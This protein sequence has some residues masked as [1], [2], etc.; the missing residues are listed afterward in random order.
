ML[1]NFLII[2]A[3]R[4][5]TSYISK[6]IMQHPD[7]FLHPQKELHFFD[8]HYNKG[9]DYY[10]TFFKNVKKKAVGE[11][12]PAYLYFAHIPSLIK[13]HIPNIKLI[14]SLRNPTDRAY[15]H[16]WN[17]VAR[18]KM[19]NVKFYDT[20][21]NHLDS[22]GRLIKEG[23]YY[24]MLVRYYNVFPK[25]KILILFYEELI[26]KTDDNFKK[27]FSFLGVDYSF[28]PSIRKF[29]LNSSSTK[30]ANSIAIYYIYLFLIKK[31][32]FYKAANIIDKFNK[33]EIPEMNLKTRKRLDLIFDDQITKLENFLD[34]DL[35]FWR[36]H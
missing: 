33:S 30:N 13:K 7:I 16:Y 34:K 12:T 29:I 8:R 19:Q 17:I 4:S 14:A 28:T 20:F 15:S 23:F 24:D 26:K 2:G 9:I 22:Y 36:I 3:A 1:P 6:N 21:E 31:L 5:A 27:I 10:E 35:S 25:D 18:K 32:K 11:A